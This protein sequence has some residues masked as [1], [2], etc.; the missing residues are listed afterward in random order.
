LIHRK[1]RA[2]E[3]K[4][5][6]VEID[7]SQ[8]V[9]ETF[10]KWKPNWMYA[11]DVVENWLSDMSAE[12]N[13]L[14]RVWATRFT[15]EK[16]LPKRVSYVCDYQ[17]R[18]SPNYFDIHKSTGWQLKSTLPYLLTKY[19]FWM[20]EYDEGEKKPQFTYDAVEKGVQVRKVL[21]ASIVP[22]VLQ[23]MLY[24]FILRMKF[25]MNQEYGWTSSGMFLVSVLIIL[26]IIPLSSAVQTLRYAMRMRRV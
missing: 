6:S 26:F 24:F 17:L 4:F 19:S 1:F 9:G 25:S 5:F 18:A 15:F 3:R 10:T 12:G 2:F 7:E 16:G 23:L 14:V 22:T 8:W 13:H 21:L 20:K 11:P